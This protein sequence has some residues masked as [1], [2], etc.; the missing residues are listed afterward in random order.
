M[1]TWSEAN[2]SL[3]VPATGK[4]YN[5]TCSVLFVLFFNLLSHR[6]TRSGYAELMITTGA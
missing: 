3:Y 6:A 4:T 2:E 1:G 5:A